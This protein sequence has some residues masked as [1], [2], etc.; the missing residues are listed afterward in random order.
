M[1]RRTAIRSFTALTAA[2]LLSSYALSQTTLRVSLS[3]VGTQG[4][5][6]SLWGAV[7][8]DGRYVAFHSTASNLVLS[9]LNGHMPDI[10]L[11]DNQ[12]ANCTLVSLSVSGGA[13]DFGS[14]AP[15]ISAD[16]RYVAFESDATNLIVGDTN[17]MRDVFVRDV[18]TGITTRVSVDSTGA[19]ADGPSY[20]ATISADGRYVAFESEAANLV[21]GDVNLARDVFVHDRQMGFTMRVSQGF[22]GAEANGASTWPAISADGHY[23]AYMSDASN[24]V[25]NDTNGQPDVFVLDL[26]SGAT[27]RVSVDSAGVP[28]DAASGSPSISWNGQVV[29]FASNATNLVAGDTNGTGDVF[30]HDLASGVTQRVSVDGSGLQGNSLSSMQGNYGISSD[31]R[32]VAFDSLASNLVPGDTN[33]GSDLF[34]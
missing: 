31:G 30:V 33:G 3:P 19:E 32:F 4:N 23:V 16:G 21:R 9:D 12:T 5:F 17:F 18:Q 15:S 11:K 6:H 29:A 8:A 10:F 34:L 27:T 22:M 20:Y 14:I 25:P 26:Q 28:G 1:N 7:S 24:L 13:A 2:A